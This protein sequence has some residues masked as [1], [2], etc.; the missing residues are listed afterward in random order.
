MN[1]LPLWCR[2]GAVLGPESPLPLDRPFT[3]KQARGLGVSRGLLG[4]LTTCGFVRPVLHGVYVASQVPDALA[5]RLAAVRLV[6]PDHA[7]VVDRTA[8]WLHGVDALPRSAIYELPD[9]D[10]FSRDAN[11]MRR[12]GVRSGTRGLLDRDIEV[13]GGVAL[14]TPLRTACDLG[15]L[16]WRYDALSAIDGFLRLGVEPAELAFEINRFKGFRGV[17]QLRTLAPL[18]DPRAESPPESA[19]RWHWHDSGN[20]WP[21]MQMWVYCD[22]GRPR[23]R[24]DVG[25]EVVLYGVEYFGEPFHSEDTRAHDDGRL[26]WLSE[27]RGWQMEVF[28]KEDLYGPQLAATDML[29]SGYERARAT[30]GI[31]TSRIIDLGRPQ[32]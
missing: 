30:L 17:R 27:E 14:T 16:L 2:S 21:D 31:R 22:D 5:L 7:I 20:P 3:V 15:R 28:T 11:R 26:R 23:Y 8:A 13:R 12:D 29:R 24:I 6:V 9:L 10:V 25:A 1:Q 4:R 19:L 18:G 32:H